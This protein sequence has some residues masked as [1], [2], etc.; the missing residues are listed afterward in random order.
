MKGRFLGR[1][2]KKS[3]NEKKR[4]RK[5]KKCWD[6]CLLMQKEGISKKKYKGDTK[7]YLSGIK[8]LL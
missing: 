7:G 5:R 4:I 3:K 1:N 2:L 8:C 6:S